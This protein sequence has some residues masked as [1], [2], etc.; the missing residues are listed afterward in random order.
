MTD[1]P[2]IHVINWPSR[3]LHGPGRRY[4]IMARPR[5]WEHGEG[6][7]SDLTPDVDDLDALREGFLTMRAY[8]DVYVE[9][10]RG[11]PLRPGGLH[12]YDNTSSAPFAPSWEV[13]DGDTLLCSCSKAKAAAGQC[14]RVWA[15]E[16]LVEAGWRVVLDGKE[17]TP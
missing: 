2:T 4:T 11:M 15:A 5:R 14:H 17:L 10:G 12:A 9:K 13:K 16:L 6:R 1:G 3:R 8:R 7:V